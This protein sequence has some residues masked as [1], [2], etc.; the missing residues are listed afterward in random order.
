MLGD[1]VVDWRACQW[2]GS[3]INGGET[4]VVVSAPGAGCCRLDAAFGRKSSCSS[5]WTGEAGA[6]ARP[7]RRE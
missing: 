5:Q 6:T 2:N 4:Y 7:E 3:L 1:G